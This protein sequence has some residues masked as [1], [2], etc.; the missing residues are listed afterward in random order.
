MRK[1][2]NYWHLI[3]MFFVAAC[4]FCMGPIQGDPVGANPQEQLVSDLGPPA[5]VQL[6]ATP[7]S[8]LSYQVE[9]GVS[10][11]ILFLSTDSPSDVATNAYPHGSIELTTYKEFSGFAT[12]DAINTRYCNRYWQGINQSEIQTNRARKKI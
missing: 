5:Q 8:Q 12:L 7:E 6:I 11:P 3:A 1:N 9:R 10:V 2:H 4:L